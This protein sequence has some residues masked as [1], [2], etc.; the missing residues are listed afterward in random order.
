MAKAFGILYTLTVIV[1]ALATIIEDQK[2]MA[3]SNHYIYGNYWFVA[4][5]ATLAITG[6]GLAVNHKVWKNP[7]QLLTTMAITTI[8]CGGLLS[9]TT[10]ENGYIHLTKGDT[11]STF[12][13]EQ[14]HQHQLPFILKLDSF[15]TKF[16]PGTDAPMD[17][18]SYIEA[19]GKS[20][21]VS[22]NRNLV[23]DGYRFCQS[24][25]DD[26]GMGS[27][28]SVNH[29]PWGTNTTFAGYFLFILAGLV[30]LFHPKGRFRTLLSN[31]LLKKGGLFMLLLLYNWNNAPLKA[32]DS[33]MQVPVISTE[34]A[35]KLQR[36]QVVYQNRIV[37]FNTVATD[38]VK[39]LYG[40][41]NYKGLLPEQVIGGWSIAPEKWR[42]EKIIKIKS[43]QLRTELGLT[44]NYCSLD[45]LFEQD[46][47]YKLQALWFREQATKGTS[48]LEKAINEVDEKV[49]II[50]MLSNNTLMTPLPTDGSVTPLPETKISAELLYNKLPINKVLFMANI[51]IGLLAFGLFLTKGIKANSNHHIADS[52]LKGLPFVMAAA[53]LAHAFEYGLRWYI[54]GRIPL[55]NGFETMQFLALCIMLIA[56]V[57][58]QRYRFVLVFG[59]L[60]SGFTLLVAYLGQ[61]NPQITPLMPVLNSPW[62]ST[63]VSLIMMSY[64]LLAL[65][66]LN[67]IYALVLQS[68]DKREQVSQLTLLNQI[69]LYPATIFLGIGILLGAVWA[70]ESWGAYWSW[71]PKEVWALI[72]LMVYGAGVLFPNTK[73]FNNEKHFHWYMV[74][75]FTTVLMTY[76]GVNYLLGGMH[77]YA[78][79]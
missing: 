40:K 54:S 52:I 10:S 2:G 36:K 30:A 38:F 18:V 1:L 37:P 45:D 53:L 68:Q 35:L 59:F 62:L 23:K 60:M 70:N 48:K 21:L 32:N 6:I 61:M 79:N 8:L 41:A 27:W 71:D 69:L 25:F 31:P 16:Y 65:I 34:D 49:G 33:L 13:D 46:G 39:K 42:N 26:A 58:C 72:T 22:M 19:N 29:D 57:L 9:Y 47:K 51:T 43:D 67:S 17:Y 77:S 12:E 4:L 14:H 56:V 11:C 78:G 66:M 7:S 5:W 74:L 63:H 24:S 55:N 50:L 20:E 73:P 44:G 64:A 75:S 15:S 76:F 28:L 3:F